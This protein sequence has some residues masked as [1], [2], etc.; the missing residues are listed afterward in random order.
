[1]VC[2]PTYISFHCTTYSIVYYHSPSVACQTT[3]NILQISPSP[4]FRLDLPCAD[5]HISIV[6]A[7]IQK[8]QSGEQMRMAVTSSQLQD[9]VVVVVVDACVES[10]TSSL[11]S[12]R[13]TC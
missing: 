11:P 3:E 5:H 12:S 9:L 2:L 4:F 7:V 6:V 10:P 1:M 8:M 13:L